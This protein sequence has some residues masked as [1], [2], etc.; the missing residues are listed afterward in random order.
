[1][2]KTGNVELAEHAAEMA[3]ASDP[4]DSGSFTLLSNIYASKGMWADAK[5]DKSHRKANQI[6]EVLDDLL[7]QI[8]WRGI[9]P[10]W[11]NEERVSLCVDEVAGDEAKQQ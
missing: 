10:D 8:K 1:M 4:T 2:L 6:Y 7:L 5:K 3:I 11:I 9:K